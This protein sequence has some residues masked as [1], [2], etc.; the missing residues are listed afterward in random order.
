M[1]EIQ[2]QAKLEELRRWEVVDAEDAEAMA[3]LRDALFSADGYLQGAGVTNE[4]TPLR[5]ML[6]RKLAAYFYEV[7]A[8]GQ[9]GY[10]DLP[11]DL[12]ALVLQLRH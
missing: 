5:D 9:S 10:P 11:P 3:N 4:D 1:T 12:N 2:L 8:P 7:R 6:L